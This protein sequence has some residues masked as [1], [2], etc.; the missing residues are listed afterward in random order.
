MDQEVADEIRALC[1]GFPGP[2]RREFGVKVSLLRVGRK[3]GN[4]SYRDDLGKMFLYSLILGPEMFRIVGCKVSQV[5]LKNVMIHPQ[6]V[7]GAERWIL[8]LSA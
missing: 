3:Q 2:A 7:K 5:G 1:L 8:A 6:C 4:L